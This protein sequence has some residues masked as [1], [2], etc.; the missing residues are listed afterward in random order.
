[1][2]HRKHIHE[3]CRPEELY[4]D[5]DTGEGSDELKKVTIQAKERIDELVDLWKLK[6][7]DPEENREVRVDRGFLLFI[8]N[9]SFTY[10]TSW[11][12]WSLG[13]SIYLLRLVE[14]VGARINRGSSCPQLALDTTRT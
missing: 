13:C 4:Y 2:A 14:A 12:Y 7:G 5:D 1:M 6:F 11:F 3:N 8:L 9:L 10:S